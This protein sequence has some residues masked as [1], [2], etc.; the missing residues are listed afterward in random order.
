MPG[1]RPEA[2]GVEDDRHVEP[3]EEDPNELAGPVATP[4][5]GA[6]RDRAGSLRRFQDRVGGIGG[7]P[8]LVVCRTGPR[9]G[10]E[11]PHLE[12]QVARLGHADGD[13]PRS[14]P[15]RGLRGE[16]RRT[17]I[18]GRAPDNED[19][20]RRVL[21]VARLPAGNERQDLLGD[22]RVPGRTGCEPDIRHLDLA[23]TEPARRDH[24]PHLRRMEGDRGTS[25]YRRADHLSGRGVD[26]RRDVQGQDRDS[27]G[28]DL[29]DVACGVRARS[30]TEA[31][32][33]QRVDDDLGAPT[34]LG[35]PDP[36]LPD[37]PE[38][39]LRVAL[40]V[41][42]GPRQD[43]FDRPPGLVEDPGD[44]EPVAP[45]RTRP[46]PH[47]EPLGVGETPQPGGGG[48]GTGPLHQLESRAL[49]G[50]LRRPHLGGGVQRLSPHRRRRRSLP[51]TPSSES[52]RGRSHPP[53]RVRPSLSSSRRGGPLASA[54]PRSRSPAT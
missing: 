19:R 49:E 34:G 8:A 54:G 26:A 45:V 50:F 47:G 3:V 20:A 38:V 32:P 33:E 6:D 10:L 27:D 13:D 35:E 48:G 39:R 37:A 24:E 53:A 51:P 52:S 2:V 25:L 42:L 1:E 17:R 22:P 14:C 16:R 7:H 5:A 30:A 40:H 15:H 43:D 31:R 12:D 4:Q 21:V 46:A 36:E 29:L 11:Q 9:H 28:V 44:D 18:A 23:G 41:V